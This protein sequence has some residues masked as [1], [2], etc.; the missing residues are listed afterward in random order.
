MLH[1]L[2]RLGHSLVGVIATVLLV[3]LALVP[4][5]HASVPT[6]I[7]EPAPIP[8]GA[9]DDSQPLVTVFLAPYRG[10]GPPVAVAVFVC[11]DGHWRGALLVFARNVGRSAGTKEAAFCL[12]DLLLK[13]HFILDIKWQKTL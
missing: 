2:A 8:V 7:P 10:H 4:S 1:W 9:S 12:H 3:V 5:A 13:E 11:R 6:F